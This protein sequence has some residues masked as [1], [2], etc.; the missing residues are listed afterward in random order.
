MRRYTAHGVKESKVEGKRCSVCQSLHT[1]H[2]FSIQ[3]HVVEHTV[4]PIFPMTSREAAATHLRLETRLR[5]LRE[6]S[7]GSTAAAAHAAV[8]WCRRRVRDCAGTFYHPETVIIGEETDRAHK[9]YCSDEK[10]IMCGQNETTYEAEKEEMRAA[11]AEYKNYLNRM[12]GTHGLLLTSRGASL[13]SKH[14]FLAVRKYKM[15][16]RHHANGLRS[17]QDDSGELVLMYHMST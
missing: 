13:T 12:K 9:A 16:V 15:L 4:E 14:H 8:E 17:N 10:M 1:I 5:S 7:R 3:A 6:R 2:P 11:A